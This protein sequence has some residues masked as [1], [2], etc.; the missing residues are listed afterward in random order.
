MKRFFLP[1]L[2]VL[3]QAGISVSQTT[4]PERLLLSRGKFVGSGARPMGLGGTYTGVADDYSSVW[5][6]PAGLAQVK[7][8]EMQASLD[9]AGFNNSAT[10]FGGKRDGNTSATRLNNFG[11][12]FPVPVYQGALSFAFGY[13]QVLG[14]DRRTRVV[15]QEAL[16]PYSEY[17]VLETGRLGFWTLA[18]AMDVSPNIALGLG[19]NYWTGVDER[20]FAG[21]E[22][23]FDTTQ[24][25]PASH[26]AYTEQAVN[27]DLSAWGAN[28]GALFR[29]GRFAR[30]GMMIQTPLDVSLDENWSEDGFSARSPLYSMTNPAV[31]RMGASFTPGRWLLAADIE[32]RDWT[33]MQFNSEPP[34]DGLSKTSANQQIKDNYKA[35][36]RISCGGEYLLPVYGLRARAGYAFDPH[37][38]GPAGS[39]EDQHNFSFGL[40]VLVDR[41]VMFDVAYRF[42]SFNET[43]AAKG[44]AKDISTTTALVT[45][46]YRM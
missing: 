39:N 19:I 5:W 17:D 14:F 8:I 23:R 38:Y 18:G 6:N 7:R 16:T 21:Y 28:V 24:Q 10:Y 43:D 36:T 27:T 45:L 32:Y 9:R 25:P 20:T 3:C 30:L 12:V 42:S 13:N 15:S 31:F 37:N 26:Y 1:L 4:I 35:S 33:T 34:I 44:I 46:S 29:I 2:L 22:L 41:S 11:F 40:G